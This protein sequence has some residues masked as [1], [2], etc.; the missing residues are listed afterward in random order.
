MNTIVPLEL[1]YTV[2][3]N[4]CLFLVLFTLL[5]TYVLDLDDKKNIQYITI[6]GYILLV[7]SIIYIG[8]RP[9]SHIFGDTINY[10]RTFLKY[11]NG[12]SIGDV[13]DFGW[14]VFLKFMS[15]VSSIYTFFT[16]CAFIY[17]FPLYRI[18]KEFFKEYWFYAFFMFIVSFSFWSYGVNGV[19]NGAACSLFLWGVSYHKNKVVM[20]CL[21]LLGTLFHKT[22]FLPIFAFIITYYYNNPKTFLI[23]WL[24]CIPFSFILGGTFITLFSSLGFGGD[25][26]LSGYLSGDAMDNAG[27]RWD[28]IF[29]SAFAVFAAWYFIIKKGFKDKYYFQLVNTYLICN[30]FWIL[31]ITA[32]FSNRFAYLSWFMMA[33]VIIYPLLK[34]KFFKNQHIMIGKVMLAYFSFTFLMYQLYYN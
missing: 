25:E 14:H 27:F 10:Y 2:Y 16:I 23:S 20:A 8:Q 4:V 12:A 33:I 5:H 17:I 11:S 26:R 6:T 32:N 18:S 22:V 29:H 15:G 13:N 24:A 30:S 7:F 19:R 34:Q 1:Y 31:I 3:I 9:P 28:F 21:F